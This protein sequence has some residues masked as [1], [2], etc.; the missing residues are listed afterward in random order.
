MLRLEVSLA[1]VKVALEKFRADPVGA[2]EELVQGWRTQFS[3]A[4]TQLMEAEIELFLGEQ[5]QAGQ[6]NARNGYIDRS[7]AVKGVGQLAVRVPRDRGGK[8]AS[9][10]LPPRQ[11]YDVRIQQD[12]ALMHLGGMSTRTI[13]L[14]SERFFGR[15]L[16]AQEVSEATATLHASVEAW[17]QR[18]LVA[19][20]KYLFLDGTYFAVRRK[21]VGREPVLVA[22]GVEEDGTR[23]V[24]GF[25][26]GDKESANNWNEFLGDLL[27]RGLQPN[28]VK[29]GLMDGLP[30]LQRIFTQRFRN[31]KVQRCQ[32]HKSRNVLAKVPR[33]FHEE[34]RPAMSSVFYNESVEDSHRA[35]AAIKAKYGRLCPDAIKCLEDDLEALLAFYAFPRIEWPSLRTTNPIE[36]LNK[37]YKRRTNSMEIVGGEKSMYTLLAYIS[38]RMELGW[39]SA[40]LGQKNVV[41]LSPFQV[42][43]THKT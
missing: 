34:F 28:N 21:D 26:S 5:R 27:A 24:L 18:P 30:G 14:M 32:I 22:L 2:L 37:E 39:R 25:Q 36:R 4:L 29:L 11:R 41:N 35:F 33:R 9:A 15:R 8:F 6:A 43:L 1:N 17:R 20:Y 31:A 7:F 10:I 40:K 13:E 38:M 3:S 19:Q 12:L 23:G 42:A 16:S